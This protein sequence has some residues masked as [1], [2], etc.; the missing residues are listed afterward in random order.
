MA[1]TG[2]CRQ[3]RDGDLW[4]RYKGLLT[5]GRSCGLQR[6]AATIQNRKESHETMQGAKILGISFGRVGHEPVAMKANLLAVSH[7]VVA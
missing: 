4:H 5:V 1:A 3:S 6:N 7:E 2:S